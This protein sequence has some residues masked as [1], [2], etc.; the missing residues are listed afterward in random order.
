MHGADTGCWKKERPT[1]IIAKEVGFDRMEVE[2]PY[3]SR[4]IITETNRG[5]QTSDTGKNRCD[6][7]WYERIGRLRP[8][9]QA[10]PRAECREGGKTAQRPNYGPY[11]P[12]RLNATS[13]RQVVP[14][15][16]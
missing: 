2:L 10:V 5:L 9:D 12:L 16:T 15:S 11:T 13:S 7:P 3:G 14:C 8:E 4:R 1:E 6:Q